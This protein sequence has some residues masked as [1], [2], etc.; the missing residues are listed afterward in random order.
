MIS[1]KVYN[2][3]LIQMKPVQEVTGEG[4]EAIKNI[5]DGKC[6]GI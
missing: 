3:K 1:I 6:K 5:R 2:I 4:V